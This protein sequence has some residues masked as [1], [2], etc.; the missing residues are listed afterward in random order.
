MLKTKQDRN[1]SQV[2]SELGAVPVHRSA[3]VHRDE[4]VTGLTAIV[5]LHNLKGSA[6]E[7]E[8]HL[9]TESE[10]ST[11][12]QTQDFLTSTWHNPCSPGFQRPAGSAGLSKRMSNSVRHVSMRWGKEHS[13]SS[14]RACPVEGKA[15]P[16]L[17]HS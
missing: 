13:A 3:Q 15:L 14:A 4:S 11:I 17:F 1:K 6:I 12:S 2:V 10:T 7:L 9:H 8:G 5:T 16:S